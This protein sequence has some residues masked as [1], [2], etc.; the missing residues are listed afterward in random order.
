[1]AIHVECLP[2]ETLLRKLGYTRRQVQHYQGKSRVFAKMRSLTDQV[3]LV[4]EDPMA[5][6]HPYE[7][8]LIAQETAHGV[9]L[10][11]DPNRNNKVLVLRVKLEDWIISACSAS[12]IEIE[13]YGL[14]PRPNDLHHVI[15][16]RISAYEHLLDTLL[17]AHNPGLETLRTWL[18]S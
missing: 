11:R 9:T 17:A 13:Q 4:D 7:L 5:A 6:Q 16:N 14:P 10:R 12:G 18:H 15:N 3:G 2:D 8:S 1:M